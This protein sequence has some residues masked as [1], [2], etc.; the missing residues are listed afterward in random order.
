MECC[1]CNTIWIDESVNTSCKQIANQLKSCNDFS[2]FLWLMRITKPPS[3]QISDA[4][5]REGG[6]LLEHWFIGCPTTYIVYEDICVKR[7][8]GHSENIVTVSNSALLFLHL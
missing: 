5:T 1:I 3:L 8:V 4:V 6:K 7:Y 2:E